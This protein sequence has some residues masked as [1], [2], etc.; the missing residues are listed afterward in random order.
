MQPQHHTTMIR[1]DEVCRRTGLSKS[2]IHRLISDAAFPPAVKL[3]ARAVGWVERD[4]EQWIQRQ[5]EMSNQD[6]RR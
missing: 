3:S 6:S 1:I 5:I 2:H 4:V